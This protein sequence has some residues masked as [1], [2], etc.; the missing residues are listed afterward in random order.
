MERP[1]HR[2]RRAEQPLR[3]QTNSPPVP[4]P[5]T[6]SPGPAPSSLL[7]MSYTIKN[8]RDVEDAAQKFGFS[9]VQESRFARDDLDSETIGLA[10]HVVRPGKRQA[11][12]HRHEQAE[13]I[14]VVLGG[15]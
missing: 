5:T 7:R 14:Y 11:F 13:E 10:F 3:A 9:E 4:K 8:L 1:R 2:E 12:A 6:K 15:R